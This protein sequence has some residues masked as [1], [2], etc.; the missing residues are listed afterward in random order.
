MVD[1]AAA[2]E[3]AEGLGIPF[4]ETSAKVRSSSVLFWRI[5]LAVRFW[6]WFCD[7]VF[8][9]FVEKRMSY[10]LWLGKHLVVIAMLRL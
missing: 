1:E 8:M 5:S 7:S 3:L 6:R 2:K 9:Y 4:L 10:A